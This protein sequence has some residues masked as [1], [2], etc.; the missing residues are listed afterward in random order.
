MEIE[1]NTLTPELFLDLYKSV[2][3]EP[4]CIEQVRAALENTLATFICYDGSCP[5]GMVRVIGDG[6]MSYG[7][8]G[9]LCER[10]QTFRVGSQ[11]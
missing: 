6:G 9:T 1:I 11:S 8:T 7:S 3:W 4:P 10:M 2:G 5:V